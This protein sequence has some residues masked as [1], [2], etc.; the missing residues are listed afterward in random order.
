MPPLPEQPLFVGG[1]SGSWVALNLRDLWA[2]RE[3]LYFLTWRDIKVRYKQTAMGA[4][5]AVVQPLFTMLVFTIFFSKFVG[6]PSDGLPYPIFAYAGLLPWTFFANAVGTS[7]NSLIGSSGLI[8]KVYF[9][10]MIVPASAVAAGLLDLAIASVILIGLA[11]FYGVTA[12]WGLLWCLCS[13][14]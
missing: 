9:P 6:V 3:L 4:A 12:T 1:A 10:R 7:S 8:T 5:W 14:R 11:I 13:L 2:Y